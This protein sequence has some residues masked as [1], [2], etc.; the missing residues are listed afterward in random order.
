MILLLFSTDF[1]GFEFAFVPTGT[2]PIGLYFA[3]KKLKQLPRQQ[4]A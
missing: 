2:S 4:H 3:F 1:T